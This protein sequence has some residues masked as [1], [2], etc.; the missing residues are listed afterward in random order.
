[1]RNGP[2]I[3]NVIVITVL[4][5][6]VAVI[7]VSSGNTNGEPTLTAITATNSG[8][9]I[10]GSVFVVPQNAIEG[11]DPFFPRSSRVAPAPATTPT[12]TAPATLDISSLVLNGI[13]GPPRRLAMINGRTFEKGEEGEVRGL[14]G[15]R[16]LVKCEEIS[17]ESVIV[18]V[19]GD[20]RKELRLRSGL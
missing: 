1:M 13:T 6:I 2:D 20:V 14:G 4:L 5:A 10:P 15:T 16:F 17:D 19:N 7:S 8:D 18:I 11:R 12:E 3:F 9:E